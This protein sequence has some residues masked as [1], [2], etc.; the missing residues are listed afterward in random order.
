MVKLDN[1]THMGDLEEYLADF[2]FMS[3]KDNI[4]ELKRMLSVVSPSY[5]SKKYTVCATFPKECSKLDTMFLEHV[6]PIGD[7]T[8]ERY[9]KEVLLDW[10]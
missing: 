7:I 10:E 8:S 1:I 5:D 4:D 2:M 3:N 6:S 9:K